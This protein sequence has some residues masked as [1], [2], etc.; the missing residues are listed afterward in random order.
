MAD[1]ATRHVPKRYKY[2]LPFGHSAD[3]CPH[4]DEHLPRAHDGIGLVDTPDGSKRFDRVDHARSG[5]VVVR[6]GKEEICEWQEFE[7]TTRYYTI[8]EIERLRAEFGQEDYRPVYAGHFPC[9]TCNKGKLALALRGMDK[10][11]LVGKHPNRRARAIYF[12]AAGEWPK[13]PIKA[14]DGTVEWDRIPYPGEL[15]P[16]ADGEP[17]GTAG[18]ERYEAPSAAWDE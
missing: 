16:A 5:W 6:R 13:R 17:L 1:T 4:N 18:E 11:S 14:Q 3:P 10:V 15:E 7:C 9:D 12:R 2:S 8:E